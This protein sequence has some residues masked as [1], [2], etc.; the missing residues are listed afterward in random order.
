MK[1]DV[2][3]SY[4]RKKTPSNGDKLTI[5]TLKQ[6]LTNCT[7]IIRDIKKGE[8]GMMYVYL[9]ET[10]LEKQSDAFASVGSDGV[11]FIDIDDCH[12]VSNQI[13]AKFDELIKLAPY[14]I[15]AQKSASGNLHF[16]GYS[17]VVK[18]DFSK[19]GEVA[20]LYLADVTYTINKVCKI[21]LSAA[22]THNTNPAQGLFPH[23]TE[24]HYNEN[25][26]SK[27]FTDDEI[28]NLKQRYKNIWKQSESSN[29]E[30]REGFT[31]NVEY[32]CSDRPNVIIDTSNTSKI[33][34]NYHQRYQ[35]ADTLAA[36][37]Y[38]ENEVFEILKSIC[39]DVKQQADYDQQLMSIARSS[40]NKKH[41]FEWAINELRRV[42]NINLKIELDS[43]DTSCFEKDIEIPFLP[44]QYD[45]EY[46]LNKG[47]Y[48]SDIANIISI[49]NRHIYIVAPCGS[50]KTEWM[51]DYA[52]N[53]S[54]DI[55][56]PMNSTM[57]GKFSDDSI[58]WATKP[59]Q[60]IETK[61]QLMIPDTFAASSVCKEV[62]FVD[63]SHLWVE[64]DSFRESIFNTVHKLKFG[65]GKVVM[66]TGSPM[67]EH[68]LMPDTYCIK[69]V[70][71]IE[72]EQKVIFHFTHDCNET[73]KQL[74]IDAKKRHIT[75]LI[76]SNREQDKTIKL[77]VN[78]GL[79]YRKY[80]RIDKGSDF[81][82]GVDLENKIGETD[83][84]LVT[85]YLNVGNE[86][87]EQKQ[88]E[89]FVLNWN[90]ERFSA[91]T[92]YQ[93]ASRVRDS[94]ITIHV[95]VKISPYLFYYD[96][97]EVEQPNE[98]LL[99]HDIKNDGWM[100]RELQ[101][102]YQWAHVNGNIDSEM[103]AH[104]QMIQQLENYWKQF[105]IVCTMFRRL[106]FSTK[107]EICDGGVR[108]RAEKS[109]N[110]DKISVQNFILEVGIDVFVDKWFEFSEKDTIRCGNNRIEDDKMYISDI[111]YAG[112]IVKCVSRLTSIG[113]SA[114]NMEKI[115]CVSTK[116]NGL[117]NMAKLGRVGEC[118]KSIKECDKDVERIND[119][120]Q[121]KKVKTRN[122][123]IVLADE[124]TRMKV[125][126][127]IK[128]IDGKLTEQDV[129]NA[130]RDRKDIV[131]A[132]VIGVYESKVSNI[133]DIVDS[134]INLFITDG[135]LEAFEQDE[136]EKPITMTNGTDKRTYNSLTDF[137]DEQGFDRN[138]VQV[139]LSS[140]GSYKGWREAS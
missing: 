32:R 99:I 91:Q 123:L 124:Y 17:E 71:Q 72:H 43:F 4:S 85:S 119:W 139:S 81:M 134:N 51:K 105:P 28:L 128:D 49:P 36:A 26:I 106:G 50:G 90:L 93:F 52:R 8:L 94:D 76:P 70:K 92:M 97:C 23:N 74:L 79:S 37:G 131:K 20:R 82:K 109:T 103:K 67:G 30:K 11:I 77:L 120:I 18:N 15:A 130:V 19:H 5:I 132:M 31:P 129:R 138:S 95:V 55:I 122:D 38:N 140:R 115:W 59:N 56:E 86:I 110:E 29:A 12:E 133:S 54:C 87:K 63:E 68:L 25:F 101:E 1:N 41:P 73:A 7:S 102:K 121:K 136:R 60:H 44:K 125:E 34:Y 33:H 83:S 9:S 65:G 2:S 42:W 64:Q 126:Q 16:W 10:K 53:N 100:S 114:K 22:D 137:C 98:E 14:I 21:E 61:S 80:R 57:S 78:N 89:T 69:I 48:I 24:F 39:L 116:R 6:L 107:F 111:N 58:E 13:M 35:I 118:L 84:V 3:V 47:E 104:K 75:A 96:S 40:Q 45:G 127:S 27:D 62:T 135:F 117:L 46:E 66:T 88:I 113:I 112:K 108:R